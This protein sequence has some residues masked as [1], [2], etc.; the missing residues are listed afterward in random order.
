MGALLAHYLPHCILRKLD[1]VP[2]PVTVLC[3]SDDSLLSVQEML[4]WLRTGTL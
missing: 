4:T 3:P 2:L 1:V